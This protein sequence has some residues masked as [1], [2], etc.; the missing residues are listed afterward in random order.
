MS[1]Q[2]ERPGTNSKKLLKGFHVLGAQ[3]IH[4]FLGTKLKLDTDQ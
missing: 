2:R 3:T 4:T 1:D